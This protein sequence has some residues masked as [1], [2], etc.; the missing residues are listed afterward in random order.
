MNDTD[1][2]TV[3]LIIICGL[4]ALAVYLLPTIIA[5]GREH[6]YKWVICGINVVFGFTGIGYL[7]AFVWGV[8]PKQTA[9]FDVVTNDPTTNSP[10]AGQK[11]YRQMGTNARAFSEAS[12]VPS[13]Q[14]ATEPRTQTP[15]FCSNCGEPMLSGAHFCASCG[16]AASG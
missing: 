3:V 2:S 7:A 10:E 6:H 8:W 4:L 5:F 11:I 12:F 14:I 9:F 15:S 1:S 16:M 13:R